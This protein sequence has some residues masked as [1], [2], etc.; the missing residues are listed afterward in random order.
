MWFPSPCGVVLGH[1]FKVS[2]QLE[3]GRELDHNLVTV[4]GQHGEAYSQDYEHTVKLC[5]NEL[6]C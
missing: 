5:Y 1:S 4:D 3:D 2:H 6:A